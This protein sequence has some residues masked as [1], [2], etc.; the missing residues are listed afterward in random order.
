MYLKYNNDN[1]ESTYYIIS[2]NM[3]NLSG[4]SFWIK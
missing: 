4:S 1:N 3:P 2:E